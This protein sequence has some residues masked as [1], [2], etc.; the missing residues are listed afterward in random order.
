MT[1]LNFVVTL[2]I[3]G[4]STVV[5]A[6]ETGDRTNDEYYEH[7]LNE[8]RILHHYKLLYPDEARIFDYCVEQYR[9]EYG[10]FTYPHHRGYGIG[11]RVG[12]CMKKQIKLK[13]RVIDNAQ[14]QLG[15]RTQAEA[16]YDECSEYYSRSG[17]ATIGRC[18][19]TRLILDSMLQ[20]DDVEDKIYRNC[21]IVWR[22]HGHNAVDNCS[23]FKRGVFETDRLV[24]CQQPTS[25]RFRLPFSLSIGVLLTLI[26]GDN[27]LSE[28]ES[29]EARR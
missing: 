3:V 24:P 20:D 13:N 1:V 21:D 7:Y 10:P 6:A 17:A 27:A 2:F 22:K 5:C 28:S 25:C 29:R 18:V 9:K 8:L 11:S 26:V 14:D 12:T 16:M 23:I 4:L 15:G 19:K